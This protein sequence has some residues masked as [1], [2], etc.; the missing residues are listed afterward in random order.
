MSGAV[1]SVVLYVDLTEE[2]ALA[3]A[4]FVKRVGFTD[5]RSNAVD[6]EEAYR[7]IRALGSLGNALAQAGWAP[8]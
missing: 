6:T 3:L 7:M 5:C 4:Q 2:E 8:R 1:R